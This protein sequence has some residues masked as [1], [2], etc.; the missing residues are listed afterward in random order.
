LNG[1]CNEKP[2]Y[3]TAGGYVFV[4]NGKPFLLKKQKFYTTAVT[5]KDIT[6]KVIAEFESFAEA[7]RTTGISKVGIGKCANNILHNKTAGG[8]IWERKDK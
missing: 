6:G 2:E 5:Q 3:N 8:F 7:S 1:C 4:F